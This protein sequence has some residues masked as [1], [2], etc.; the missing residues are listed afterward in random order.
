MRSLRPAPKRIWSLLLATAVAMLAVP[1]GDA[2]A[3]DKMPD[4]GMAKLRDLQIKHENGKKLLR[5]TAII[6]NVGQ[7]PFQVEG[8]RSDTTSA[9]SVV[10]RIFDDTGGSR[11]IAPNASMYY[12]GDG[13]NHWHVRDLELSSFKRLPDHVKLRSGAKHGFC[14][15]DNYRYGSPASAQYTSSNSCTGGNSALQTTMGLSTGWGD[16]YWWNLVDQY[17]DVSGLPNGKYR[18]ETVVN[19]D[20]GLSQSNSANDLTWVDISMK[21]NNV[22]IESYGPS[23]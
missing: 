17:V 18:L 12:S 11:T 19:P 5:Y 20:L 3:A 8:T 23:A 21:R 10:Q 9:M 14:F 16:V 2:F 15:Y 4:L 22:T 7:G 13:H 1:A 6:V